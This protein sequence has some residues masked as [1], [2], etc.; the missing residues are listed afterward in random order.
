MRLSPIRIGDDAGRCCSARSTVEPPFRDRGIGQALMERALAE[1]KAQ[2]HRLV[3]LVGDEP[4]YGKAGF[5]AR[6]EGAGHH[7]RAGRSGAAAGR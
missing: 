4:Y 7:A 3:V 2:G 5:Q 6:P 1:A